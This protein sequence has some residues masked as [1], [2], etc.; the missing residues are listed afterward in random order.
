L[1]DFVVRIGVYAL[2]SSGAV[3]DVLYTLKDGKAVPDFDESNVH[4]NL[5]E[6]G[7]RFRGKRFYPDDG[8]EFLKALLEMMRGS[9]L[10]AKKEKD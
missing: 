5:M 6:Y 10:W 2:T 1:E 7:V 4:K 3:R 9:Y 8:E